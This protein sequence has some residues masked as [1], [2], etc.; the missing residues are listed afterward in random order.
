[1]KA[2]E[3]EAMGLVSRAFE[4][5]AFEDE[6]EEYVAALASLSRPVLR[7]AK[8]AVREGARGETEAALRRVERLYLDDLMR[9]EDPHEGLL[10]FMEKRAPAWKE[11]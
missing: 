1:V 3:A 11:A 2:R 10:A 4:A 5:D 9:L 6:V 8:R 7:L